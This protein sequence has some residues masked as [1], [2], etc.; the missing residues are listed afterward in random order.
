MDIPKMLLRYSVSI[1]E[2]V[3][4]IADLQQTMAESVCNL[5]A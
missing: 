5:S 1:E 4:L 3:D 2:T